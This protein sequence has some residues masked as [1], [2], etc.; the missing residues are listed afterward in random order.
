MKLRII[1]AVLILGFSAAAIFYPAAC[2][3]CAEFGNGDRY[4]AYENML[5]EDDANILELEKG[6]FPT[7]YRPS[8]FLD[9]AYHF[10]STNRS[11]GGG[12]NNHTTSTKCKEDTHLRDQEE[13]NFTEISLYHFRWV[14]SPIN[15]FIRPELL[16]ALSLHTYQTRSVSIDIY[17][18]LP[19][20]CS[21]EILNRVLDP[22]ASSCD[23]PPAHLNQL[24]RLTANVSSAASLS[25]VCV[26]NWELL[27]CPVHQY[28]LC[29]GAFFSLEV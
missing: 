7:N 1:H 6:F 2:I 23:N 17:L 18:G 24:N 15:L 22:S 14:I 20:N 27:G 28:A 9:V 29:V 21:P 19:F 3:S 11:A 5:V 8:I 12:K 13:L 25:F 16:T 4:S 26:L 10:I